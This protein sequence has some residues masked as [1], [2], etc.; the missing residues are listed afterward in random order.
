[1][2]PLFKWTTKETGNK[3]S[4]YKGGQRWLYYEDGQVIHNRNYKEWTEKKWALDRGGPVTVV[5]FG[6]FYCRCK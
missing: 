1:M 5:A 6:G 2:E 4:F 3:W